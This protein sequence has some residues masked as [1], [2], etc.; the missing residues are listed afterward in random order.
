MKKILYS[1]LVFCLGI[2][3]QA[4]VTSEPLENIDPTD[5]VKII[6][7]LDQ[8]DLCVVHSRIIG[9]LTNGP[10]SLCFT[11]LLGLDAIICIILWIAFFKLVFLKLLF[12]REV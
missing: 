12:V 3:A 2:V 11:K 1:A 9:H 4:Q 7:N 10:F 5:S 6:V 8:L